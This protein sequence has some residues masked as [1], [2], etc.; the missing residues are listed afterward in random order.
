[1]RYCMDIFYW[2]LVTGILITLLLLLWVSPYK[3]L[4]FGMVSY[5]LSELGTALTTLAEA[6]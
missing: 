2:T 5:I 6:I 1:M 4:I 3:D